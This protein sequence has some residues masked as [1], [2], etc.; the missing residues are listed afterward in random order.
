MRILVVEDDVKIQ[1]L[2]SKGLRQE[3]HTVDTASSGL[4]GQKLWNGQ[5]YDAVVLDI[6]LPGISGLEL[7]KQARHAKDAT[8]VL[9]LSAKG[10]VDDRIAGLETG[11]D[12]YMIKPFA[13]SEL[14]A[15]IHAITRRTQTSSSPNV[16]SLT[17]S[18]VRLD[19]LRRVAFRDDK[20]I[21]L[22]PREFALLEL[23]MK[24]PDHPLSKSFI[25]EKI[26]DYDFDPQTN[27]VDVL[28]CRLRAKVDSG[29][30]HKLIRTLRG[31]GYVFNTKQ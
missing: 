5:A 6:M 8:P 20:K 22:Q 3:G 16:T 9:I 30:D 31:I 14:S 19:L 28:V 1:A 26:W 23:M 2:I 11:A 7:L 17:L 4:E 18:G 25:L 27:V 21:E 10:A 12:D 13:F 15:R 24:N 29:Y